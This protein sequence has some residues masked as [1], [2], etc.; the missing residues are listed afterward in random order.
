MPLAD[1]PS[2]GPPTC[3]YR[4][5][6]ANDNLLYVG[7]TS[8]L[9]MRWKTHD[10][11][12]PWWREVV[13]ATVEHFDTR[14]D[15]LAAEATAIKAEKPRYNV[16]GNWVVLAEAATTEA[17]ASPPPSPPVRTGE[18]A[19]ILGCSYSKVRR[20]IDEKL[21]STASTA[22]GHHLISA[23]SLQELMDALALPESEQGEALASIKAANV[24]R[25][26]AHWQALLARTDW[27]GDSIRRI[28]AERRQAS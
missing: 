8:Q 10:K 16:R 1:L 20:Y 2:D 11:L 27:L 5:Y 22:G 25:A 15:A 18:A 19:E 17:A 21:L 9:P 13:R 4:F 12:K 28:E 6:D 26:E 24:A 7:I 23:A 14:E 3:L